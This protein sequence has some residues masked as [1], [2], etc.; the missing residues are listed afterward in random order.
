MELCSHCYY[1]DGWKCRITGGDS[2]LYYIPTKKCEY[3][4]DEDEV[5]K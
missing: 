4:D 2:C 3:I 5:E 1:D